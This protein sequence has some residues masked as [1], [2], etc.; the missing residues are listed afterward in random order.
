MG[1]VEFLKNDIV[2][3]K[4][5]CLLCW[6]VRSVRIILLEWTHLLILIN[7]G[8]YLWIEMQIKS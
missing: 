1:E 6:L 3:G 4:G 2:V 5:V 8:E 7:V